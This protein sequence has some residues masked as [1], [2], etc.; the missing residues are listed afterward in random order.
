MMA[1]TKF[2]ARNTTTATCCTI[3]LA[4]VLLGCKFLKKEK[5]DPYLTVPITQMQTDYRSSDTTADAKYKGKWLRV[6][7]VAVSSLNTDTAKWIFVNADMTSHKSRKIFDRRHVICKLR[8]AGQMSHG[9]TKGVPLTVHGWHSGPH[10][11]S[12]NFVF[13]DCVVEAKPDTEAAD[14]I[15]SSHPLPTAK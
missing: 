8:L 5:K 3:G 13:D 6:S 2:W 15:P 7:G 14:K 9:T 12:K 10:S 4:V 11:F 1:M